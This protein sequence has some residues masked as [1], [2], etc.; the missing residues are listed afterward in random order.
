MR[1]ESISNNNF[2]QLDFFDKF[3]K[4][5]K[6]SKKYFLQDGLHLNDNGYQILQNAI[7]NTLIKIK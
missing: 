7:S 4:N 3:F 5:G 2:N 1:E 6:L